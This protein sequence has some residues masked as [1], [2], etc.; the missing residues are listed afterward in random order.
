MRFAADRKWV[1]GDV[2]SGENAKT[3]EGSAVLHFDALVVSEI[4]PKIIFKKIVTAAEVAAADFDYS[5]KRKRDLPRKAH[6]LWV[7]AK[8]NVLKT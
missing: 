2:I 4:F 7:S 6:N 8:C 1:A 5:I 3:I